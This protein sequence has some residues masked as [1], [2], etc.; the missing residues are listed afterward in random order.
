MVGGMSDLTERKSLEANYLRS[1]RMESVG[2]LAGGM[3]HDLNNVLSPILLSISM[4]KDMVTNAD[5]QRC[6]DAIEASAQ[7]GANLIEN[8][9]SF[10][11]GREGRRAP[12]RI[13]R[14]IADTVQLAQKTFPR[15]IQINVFVPPDLWLV[16]G[17]ATQLHQIFMNLLVNARDALKEGGSI[18]VSAHNEELPEAW[19][20]PFR[21]KG[22]SYVVTTVRDTGPGI[23]ADIAERIFEPFFT[24]KALGSGTGLGLATVHGIVTGHGGFVRLVSAPGEGASFEVCLPA[25]PQARGEVPV[26]GE[27]VEVRGSGE[28]ILL[29]DD[30]PA[31]RTVGSQTLRSQGYRVVTAEHGRHALEVFGEHQHEIRLVLI[32][33]MMPVMGGAACIVKLTAMN[34]DL[35]IVVSSAMHPTS[36][37]LAGATFKHFL[38]KPYTAA[39]LLRSVRRALSAVPS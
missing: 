34:P 29:V 18:F 37:Q 13:S 33:L 36:D 3:A 23:P 39:T 27:S 38:P 32:D 24:T 10:A 35:P 5:G 6:L 9:L 4:L 30:E 21:A 25:E 31:I 11:R 28:L 19:C 1:Q 7:H 2:S 8:V 14:V 15:S 12:T 16:Q 26:P 20:T 22:G 17:D